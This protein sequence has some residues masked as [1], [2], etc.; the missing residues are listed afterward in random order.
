M[1]SVDVVIVVV[2]IE[3]L[4]AKANWAHLSEV[5]YWAIFV[6][7]AARH[8]A[9]LAAGVAELL[10][11]LGTFVPMSVPRLSLRYCTGVVVA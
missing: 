1:S 2:V 4:R 6:P 8:S 11:I 9:L 7:L 10:N 3:A 5:S